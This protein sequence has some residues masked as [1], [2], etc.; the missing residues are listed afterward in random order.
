MCKA[1]VKLRNSLLRLHPL[2]FGT[3]MHRHACGKRGEDDQ[4]CEQTS[5]TQPS[6][7]QME[8]GLVLPGASAPDCVPFQ[9]KVTQPPVKC[10]LVSVL[11]SDQSD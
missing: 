6:E 2:D 8:T 9:H 7:S 5:F 11:G 1:E 3:V 4:I 10:E